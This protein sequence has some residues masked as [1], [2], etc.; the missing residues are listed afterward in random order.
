MKKW[1]KSLAV[2]AMMIPA[3]VKANEGMWLISLLNKM[4]EAEMKGLGL[5]LTPEEIYSINQASLKDAIVRLNYGMCTG[6]VV[7]DKGLIFTNHHCA[8]DA[9]QTL[10]TVQNNML[11]NGFCAKA[12]TEELPIPDFKIQFLVRIDNVT[13]DVLAMLNDSMSEADREKAIATK[14]KELSSAAS[15]NGKYEVEV[16]SFFHGNE[17]YMMVYQTFRDIRLVGNPPESVGKFG[18]DTDNWMWPRHTGDFSMLRIYA[19]ASNEPADYSKE[20][21]PYKPKHFLP[22]NIGGVEEGDFHM[23][24]GFPGRTNRFLTSFGVNQATEIRNPILIE[25]LGTKLES[26]K[27]VMDRNESVDLMYAAKYASTANGWKYYIG[28]NKGLKRLNVANEKLQ[29]EQ[30]FNKWSSENADR[31]A[32]Y[33]DALLLISDYHKAWDPEVKEATYSNLAGVGGAEFMYFAIEI[34]GELEAAIKE[35]DDTKRKQTFDDVK[36]HIEAHFKEYNAEVDQ[37]V[38]TNLSN[39]HRKHVAKEKL[40]TWYQTVDGKFKGSVEAYAKKMF[41]TSI[42]TDKTKLLAFLNKPNSKTL[43]KDMAYATATSAYQHAGAFNAKNPREKMTKGYRL[44]T[45]G[46]REMA[47]N[48]KNYAPDANSTMRLT[49]GVIDDYQA[50]DAVHYDYYTTT[51]GIMEKRDNTNPEFVVPDKLAELI[52]KKDFGKYANKKGELVTCFIGNLDITGGN[53]GSPVIDGDGNLLGIAFDGNWEAMS[54]DIAFEPELQRTISVDI[55]YVLFTVEKLMGG[56]NI[57]DELK[58]ATKKPKPQPVVPTEVG[59]APSAAPSAT[60]A[61]VGAGNGPRKR[62][63]QPKRRMKRKLKK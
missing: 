4:N 13:K 9:I 31:K 32:R 10:S 41:E 3:F 8:Y 46:L 20:N 45:A 44:L 6:E 59:P 50:A 58:F 52:E 47:G 22:V 53:S 36:A 14:N 60:P 19:N 40:P 55:R 25:C 18:G 23:V 30:Q 5:N 27:S 57:I 26:W 17:F 2:I 28:Q 43:Q 39:L 15:E 12:L 49:Y 62:L 51:N 37:L 56:K 54:G 35:T 7:S 1:M 24:M 38:F 16:K 48:S 63:P 61:G 21:V 42:F 29:I 34:G 33:G 11:T